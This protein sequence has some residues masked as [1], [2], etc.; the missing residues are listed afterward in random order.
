MQLLP[1]ASSPD[2]LISARYAVITKTPGWG[3]H[4]GGGGGWQPGLLRLT[5]PHPC[6]QIFPQEKNEVYQRGLELEVDFRYTNFFS[7][8]CPPPPPP[9][10]ISVGLMLLYGA[11]DSHPFV[12]SHVASGRCVLSAA[13]AGALAGVVSALAGPSRWCTAVVLVVAPPPPG[14]SVKFA[15]NTSGATRHA[16]LQASG[17]TFLGRLP[18]ATTVA[19]PTTV[20]TCTARAAAAIAPTAVLGPARGIFDRIVGVSQS[21]ELELCI[22]IVRIHLQ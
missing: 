7:G 16:A 20:P 8:L 5:P 11:L 9:C 22:G 12:P 14:G 10:D 6:Q 13:A 4:G 3:V 1:M 21:L 15:S 2:G 19:T 17:L 18:R